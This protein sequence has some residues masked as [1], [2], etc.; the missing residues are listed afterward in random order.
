MFC[1]ESHIAE[2]KANMVNIRCR[3]LQDV[4]F[5]LLLLCFSPLVFAQRRQQA[6]TAVTKL[7]SGFRSHTAKVSGTTLHYVRGGDG[8]AVILEAIRKYGLAKKEIY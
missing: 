2:G 3:L 6:D 8:A 7:G 5:L 1:G 4:S